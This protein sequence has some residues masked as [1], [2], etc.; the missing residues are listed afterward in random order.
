[1]RP[2]LIFPLRSWGHPRRWSSAPCNRAQWPHG[3]R[4]SSS[5]R[6]WPTR[7]G[8]GPRGGRG[9]G[10]PRPPQAPIQAHCRLGARRCPGLQG[11]WPTRGGPGPRGGRGSGAPR[12][13][14]APIRALCRRDARQCPGLQGGWPTRGGPGPR[15]RWEEHAA[16]RH[17][18]AAPLRPARPGRS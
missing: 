10:A 2:Y 6:G 15:G 5:R 9:S 16:H 1:M 14:Q 7:G 17:Y 8:P 4:S 3:G 18:A 13:P 12:P 11:G